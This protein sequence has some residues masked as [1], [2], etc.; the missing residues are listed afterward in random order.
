[1]LHI[2]SFN[3]P[4]TIDSDLEVTS[5]YGALEENITTRSGTIHKQTDAQTDR[6]RTQRRATPTHSIARK[7]I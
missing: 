6:H 7:K 1:M 4:T 3:K 2:H 5:A